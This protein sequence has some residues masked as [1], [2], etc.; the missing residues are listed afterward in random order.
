MTLVEFLLYGAP[1]SEYLARANL[2]WD[3]CAPERP[4]WKEPLRKAILV[5]IF[6]C[7]G[8]LTIGGFVVAVG[9]KSSR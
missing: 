6:E 3:L 5:E 1:Q 8:A 4:G 2:A 7:A 9:G